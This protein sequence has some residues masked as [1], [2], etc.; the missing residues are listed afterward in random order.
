MLKIN[1]SNCRSNLPPPNVKKALEDLAD[2]NFSPQDVTLIPANQRVVATR[3]M[4]LI[5]ELQRFEESKILLKHNNIS[6]KE[7]FKTKVLKPF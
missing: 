5:L 6:S 2:M 1:I 4:N 7:I 3:D